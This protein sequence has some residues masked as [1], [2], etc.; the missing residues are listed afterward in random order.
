MIQ[1]FSLGN[2]V[3]LRHCHVTR[4]KQSRISIQLLRPMCLQEASLNALLPTVLLRGSE[5]HPD[6]LSINRHLDELYGATVGD[7]V[8][9]AGDYQTVGFYAAFTDDRFALPGD[10]ILAPMLDFLR[11][12]LWEPLTKN[13]V[14]SKEIVRSEQKNLIADMDAEFND[15]RIYAANSLMRQMCREDSFGV[16]RIGTREEMATITAERLYAHY[17][18]ILK[19]SPVEIFYVGSAPA[20]LIMDLIT[21]MFGRSSRQ[22]I[23]L[24]PQTPFHDAGGQRQTQRCS[25]AQSLINLGYTTPITD[26][27]PDFAAMRIF[28]V[29][30]GAGMT[31]KLF[32]QVREVQS[33][34]YFIGSDYSGAKGLLTI[35]AGIDHRNRN[36]A[37]Q[38]IDHQLAACCRGEISPEELSAAKAALLSSLQSIGDTPGGI[39]S[40]YGMQA[41]LGIHRSPDA[42]RKAVE[43][44]TVA[45]VIRA[46]NSVK[47]H[48]EFYL[49][50]VSE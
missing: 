36:A 24:P 17:Q 3:T 33:L 10:R 14:F 28:N 32:L 39:E 45:D 16:P 22:V 15:K 19:E 21:P 5:K 27:H 38:A 1:T 47:F 20:E 40:Y 42:Y 23:S 6:L 35:S 43:S 25:A 12:L 49:E 18:K 46:A 4:F 2:G 29:I 11:E 34:C 8:R 48:S 7:L 37:R 50:G 31:S 26:R 13:G 41:L 9:R 30:L 44:V